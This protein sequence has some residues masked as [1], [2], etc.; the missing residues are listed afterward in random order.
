MQLACSSQSNQPPPSKPLVREPVLN[1]V[2]NT[3]AAVSRL[4]S[5][6]DSA[7]NTTTVLLPQP[8]QV[9]LVDAASPSS[10][11][12]AANATAAPQVNWIPPLSLMVASPP[13]A[14]AAAAVPTPAS[15]LPPPPLAT[16][17]NTTVAA[18]APSPQLHPSP[19][20]VTPLPTP[21][22]KP[23]PTTTCGSTISTTALSTT[24]QSFPS[25]GVTVSIT[26]KP[27]PTTT[28][29][30]SATDATSG[31]TT[32]S[33]HC[34]TTPS[35]SVT[36]A[37]P[38]VPPVSYFESHWIHPSSGASAGFISRVTCWHCSLLGH[39]VPRSVAS[40]LASAI[41]GGGLL[42]RFTADGA[43]TSP[44]QITL[45]RATASPPPPPPTL[46]PPPTPA[47]AVSAVPPPQAPAPAGATAGANADPQAPPI[48][49]QQQQTPPA[50]A[51][52]SQTPPPASP[53]DGSSIS[54]SGSSNS[55]SSSTASSSSSSSSG[56][57]K[58]V[59]EPWVI[60][61]AAVGGAVLLLVVT[62]VAVALVRRRR[63]RQ[64]AASAFAKGYSGGA[65]GMGPNKTGAS[66]EDLDQHAHYHAGDG[67]VNK[68]PQDSM[69]AFAMTASA[70]N[71][72]AARDIHHTSSGSGSG[73][74]SGNAHA[75][76]GSGN[77][78][79]VMGSPVPWPRGTGAPT[80]EVDAP[81]QQLATVSS[82]SSASTADALEVRLQ[83]FEESGIAVG[84]G[85]QVAAE[86]AASTATRGSYFSA[87]TVAPQ[88]PPPIRVGQGASAVAVGGSQATGVAASA[89]P[90]GRANNPADARQRFWSQYVRGRQDHV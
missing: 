34:I 58:K 32:K 13:P 11:S 20:S 59:I 1:Q 12:T 60:P 9:S 45:R 5:G 42:A 83:R 2:K 18:P 8:S 30:S 63:A 79:V 74:G 85:L 26:A 46:V 56:G 50:G 21:V 36:A 4:L 87:R 49:T 57:A 71:G 76:V 77:A 40:R 90:A 82:V 19:P 10:N 53:V 41:S 23:L 86:G 3:T 80:R 47:A 16:S 69:T 88:V 31:V 44:S 72:S 28:P 6:S 89:A 64:Q 15:Q 65:Q 67:V 37:A 43:P 73:S 62:T 33:K 17:A 27:S 38:S 68:C 78:G 25:N 48:A 81:R 54:S 35:C 84:P 24:A 7:A 22:T 66:L 70:G 39:A 52:P 75:S 61:I 55:G 14:T 29:A 51:S